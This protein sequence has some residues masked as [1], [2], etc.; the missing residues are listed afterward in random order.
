MKQRFFSK[1]P[2]PQQISIHNAKFFHYIG[3]GLQAPEGDKI[4]MKENTGDSNC[5]VHLFELKKAL[6]PPCLMIF[7][8]DKAGIL[9][10]FIQKNDNTWYPSSSSSLFSFFSCSQNEKLNIASNLPQNFFSCIL[11]SPDKAYSALTGINV[12]FATFDKLLCMFTETIAF[13]SLTTNNFHRLFRSNMPLPPMWRKFLLAQRLMK[14]I[15]TSMRRASII[16]QSKA[17]S[18]KS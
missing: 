17:S 13:D 15:G 5:Y 2:L 9:K 3:L 4:F 1:K 8:C 7:D 6:T 14:K 12:N 11:L 18:G 16:G 10:P